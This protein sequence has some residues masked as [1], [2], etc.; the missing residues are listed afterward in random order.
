MPREVGSIIFKILRQKRKNDHLVASRRRWLEQGSL[1]RTVAKRVARRKLPRNS[2]K[3]A[4]VS[5]KKD[6]DAFAAAEFFVNKGGR[7]PVKFRG[8]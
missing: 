2:G 8:R 7:K 1:P 6:E 3:C 4:S 5:R